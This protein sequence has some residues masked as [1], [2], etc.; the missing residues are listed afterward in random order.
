MK[1]YNI[2]KFVGSSYVFSPA[3]A[4]PPLWLA[5]A[6]GSVPLSGSQVLL[7][8]LHPA[9]PTRGDPMP[10]CL[11]HFRAEGPRAQPA[12]VASQTPGAFPGVSEAPDKAAL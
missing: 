8:S 12:S 2:S 1:K 11:M 4:P 9:H 10:G 6:G 5:G 3:Q 7:P